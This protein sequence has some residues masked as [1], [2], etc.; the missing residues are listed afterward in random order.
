MEVINYEVV[1]CS[2][3]IST[4]VWSYSIEIIIVIMVI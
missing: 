2:V 1:K 4:A 3:F